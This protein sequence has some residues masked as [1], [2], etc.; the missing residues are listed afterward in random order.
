[1]MVGLPASGK[2]TWVKN[3]I[4]EEKDK[5]YNVIGTN[6]IMERMKVPY[7]LTFE[8]LVYTTVLEITGGWTSPKSH[9]K[10]IQIFFVSLSVHIKK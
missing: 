5:K 6:T 8:K 10:S 4:G 3:Y 2:S 7:I 9:Q 1:M